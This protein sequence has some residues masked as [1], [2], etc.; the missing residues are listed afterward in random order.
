MPPN[1]ATRP[2]QA[3]SRDLTK[4]LIFTVSAIFIITSIINYGLN[5]HEAKGLYTQKSTEYLAY[6]RD[7]L[8]V[9]LWNIDRDWIESICR[10]FSKNETVALLKVAGEDGHY[11]FEMV[12]AQDPILIKQKSLVLYKGLVIGSVELGLTKRLYEKS[13]YQMLYRSVLQ[14]IFVIIG[15]MFS[16]KLILNRIVQRPL[17]HLITRIEEI[18]AGE[19]RQQTQIFDHFEMATILEKFNHMAHKVKS[20]ENSLIDTNKKLESEI[21]DRREAEEAL[22]ESEKRYRQ[23]VEDLPVGMFRS[24]PL[25]EGRFQMA[26]PALIKMFGYRAEEEFT[27]L[28]AKNIYRDPGMRRHV[29]EM[30][31]NEGA[32]Q[33]LELEFRKKDGAHL[34]GLTSAHLVKD[35]TGTP[36]YIDGIIEDITERKNLER[37][38]QQTQKMEAIGTLASGIAHDFNNILSTMFGFTEVV[39]MRHARG[40]EIE[41][42]LDEILNAGLRA[43]SLIKQILTFSRQTEV[44]KTAT[45]IRPIIKETIKFLRASL[46]ATIEIRQN[47][48]AMDSTVLADPTQIHQIL[49]NLCTNSAQAMKDGGILAVDLE[50]VLFD[51]GSDI[52]YSELKTGKY[53]RLTVCDTGHGIQKVHL[54]RIFEPFFTSKPRGEGTGMG[55]AVIHGIV[56][57]MGGG[58]SV[59]SHPEQGTTFHVLLPKHEGEVKELNLSQYKPR[60]GRGKILFVDDEEGFIVSGREILEQLGYQVV[61]AASGQE[62][63]SAFKSNPAD[64]DLVITDMVMPKMT[65]LD[66]GK[67]VIKIR[68]DIPIILCTGFSASVGSKT[69]KSAGIHHILMK[70]LL[71]G[72]LSDAIEKALE[73]KEVI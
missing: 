33:G 27:H 6:L 49:M 18:S 30:L 2:Q 23:L 25:D 43:R 60:Q 72:E 17:N 3:L 67:E 50:E 10:S 55:L 1:R 64:F 57:N 62:G 31:F 34:I 24:S 26:N 21:V 35:R 39:K 28:S 54:E 9:P 37:Q 7:N 73:N 15:L 70:P 48:R 68:P 12:N 46:P 38:M 20:R 52:Q 69:K 41:G 8:E 58:I 61:T 42:Q 19:Y 32:I 13:N 47:I 65:G 4:K 59:V 53:I 36:L 16:T 66:L 22:R 45:P 29:L 63:I 44:K 56:N 5:A 11:L 71:A 14:M 51:Q 40:D